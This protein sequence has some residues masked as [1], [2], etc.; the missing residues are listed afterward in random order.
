[1]RKWL[2]VLGLVLVLVIPFSQAEASTFY[3]RVYDCTDNSP[4]VGAVVTIQVPESSSV[5]AATNSSGIATFNLSPGTYDVTVFAERYRIRQ[6]T[7]TFSPGSTLP[8]CLFRSVEGFW[9]VVVDILEWMGDMHAG[10]RGWAM[11]RLKNLEDGVF[12][13]T[14]LE[15]WVGGYNRPIPVMDVPRGAVVGRVDAFFNMTVAPPQDSRSQ[16]PPIHQSRGL[17]LPEFCIHTGHP[18]KGSGA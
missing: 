11:L 9:R 18:Y 12:N 10:G 6:L 13:I 14:R 15:V 17:V 1:M 4:I 3:V 2:T 5:T 16:W 8:F 7:I